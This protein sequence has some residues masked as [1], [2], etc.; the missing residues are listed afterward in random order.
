MDCI[1]SNAIAVGDY[2][3]I[4]SIMKKNDFK[5]LSESEH[6]SI[7][8]T[9]FVV[10]DPGVLRC[11]FKLGC[12]SPSV[13]K[14]I[15]D[16]VLYPSSVE[17]TAELIRSGVPPSSLEGINRPD[18]IIKACDRAIDDIRAS[19]STMLTMGRMTEEKRELLLSLLNY[20]LSGKELL[21]QVS[22]MNEQDN[23]DDH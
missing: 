1:L 21:N 13:C 4:E 12:L 10:D 14:E 19:F 5:I 7:L 9:V 6:V 2:V 8:N 3:E 23:A 15:I 11:L 18:M 20:N 16:S 17:C 22:K